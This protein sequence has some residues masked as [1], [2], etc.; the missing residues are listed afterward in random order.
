MLN[1][2]MMVLIGR[3]DRKPIIIS[4]GGCVTMILSLLNL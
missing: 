4:S 3:K 1:K 2:Y